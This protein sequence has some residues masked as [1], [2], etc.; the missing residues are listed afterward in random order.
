MSEAEAKP[1]VDH[2]LVEMTIAAPVEAVWD[3]LKDPAKIYNWHGWDDPTLKDEIEFIY[4]QYGNYDDA[5]KV[6]S[7][8]EY[9]GVAYR[10]EAEARG[11]GTRAPGGRR[12]ERGQAMG[13]GLRGCRRG[14]DQLRPAAALRAGAARYRAAAGALSRRQREAG[15]QRADR[16]ARPVGAARP[17]PT[18]RR[19]ASICRPASMSR[20]RSGTARPWQLGLTVP[21]W[22][23]GLLIVTDKS[24]TEKAPDGR[25]MVV[26][27]IY[28]LSD[29]GFRRAGIA[30]ADLVG[31]ALP[32]RPEAGLRM[33]R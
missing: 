16:G 17:S 14:L 32:D 23:D 26:L 1:T 11:D 10:F 27:T 25:G 12:G 13:R 28:G 5:A 24:V 18:A 21:Q 4:G 7:F 3:A 20:A 31:R 9:E 8:G 6:L 30:L 29:D 22:G 33:K 2:V 19:S 15:R